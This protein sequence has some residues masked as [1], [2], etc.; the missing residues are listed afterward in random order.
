ML[1][2]NSELLKA[3]HQGHVAEAVDSTATPVTPQLTSAPTTPKAAPTSPTTTP[4]I[5]PTAAKSGPRG[6]RPAATEH[7]NRSERNAFEARKRGA[8]QAVQKE[9]DRL[10][11]LPA[12]HPQRK[13]LFDAISSVAKGDYKECE[14]CIS[15]E[16]TKASGTPSFGCLIDLSSRLCKL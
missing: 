11:S 7:L 6:G 2:N 8:P 14:L 3:S 5:T 1:S 15:F 16:L 12:N 9:W 13:Q 10:K 4:R